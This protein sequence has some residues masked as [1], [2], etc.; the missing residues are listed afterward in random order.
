M[1]VI[2][3][4]S[5]V[6]IWLEWPLRYNPNGLSQALFCCSVKKHDI[7]TITRVLRNMNKVL[8]QKMPFNMHSGIFMDYVS[9]LYQAAF[10]T[11]N[12]EVTTN[13]TNSPNKVTSVFVVENSGELSYHLKVQP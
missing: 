12:V 8:P 5:P 9:R 7:P 13:F 4:A 6:Q 10:M 3:T 11:E 2:E 1:S